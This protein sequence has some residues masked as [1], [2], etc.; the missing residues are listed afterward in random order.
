VEKIW[1]RY[2]FGSIFPCPQAERAASMLE[3]KK[4]AEGAS[5]SHFI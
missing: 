2:V 4:G 5:G 3:V 1:L